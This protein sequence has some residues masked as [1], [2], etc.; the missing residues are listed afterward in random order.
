MSSKRFAIPLSLLLA[1]ALLVP[2]S[3][4]PTVVRGAPVRSQ[5]VERPLG[6]SQSAFPAEAVSPLSAGA[7]TPE[8]LTQGGWW[9]AVQADISRSEYNVT[10]LAGTDPQDARVGAR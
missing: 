4:L 6:G 9:A 5:G 1:A 8:G 3:A 2:A 7:P 10:P